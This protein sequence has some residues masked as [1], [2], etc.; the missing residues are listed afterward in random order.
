MSMKDYCRI[1]I[2]RLEIPKC[3]RIAYSVCRAVRRL[4]KLELSRGSSQQRRPVVDYIV[5]RIIEMGTQSEVL[6]L[7]Y[8]NGGGWIMIYGDR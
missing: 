4:S 2:S 6:F 5:T 7:F 3:D 8:D 1:F